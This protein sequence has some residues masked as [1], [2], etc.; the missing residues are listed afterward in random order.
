MI[1]LKKFRSVSTKTLIEQLLKNSVHKSVLVD[2]ILT[3]DVDN[4]S[5]IALIKSLGSSDSN[6]VVGQ[7]VNSIAGWK[8]PSS[9]EIIFRKINWEPVSRVIERQLFD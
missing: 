6:R 4:S 5:K 3:L 8:S 2:R 1:E 7:T 9:A